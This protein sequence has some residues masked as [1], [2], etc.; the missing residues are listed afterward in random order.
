MMAFDACRRWLVTGC[1]GF[2]GSN[3]VE[4]LLGFGASVVGLDDLSTGHHANL[5]DIRRRV[6][7]EA[8]AR[9]RFI[10]GSIEDAE[11]C[12][13]ACEDV[14]FVLHQAAVASIGGS[15]K[16]PSM[17]NRV[18]VGGTI[19]VLLAAR[20][21][22]VQRVVYASS[23]SVYGDDPS[24]S[25]IESHLGRLLS[26]YA[27]SKLA[28]EQYAAV[29]EECYGLRCVGLRYFNVFGC[30]QDPNGPYAAVIPRWI[31]QLLAGLACEIFGD[32]RTSRDFCHVDNV[33]DA[34]FC[35]ALLPLPE[36]HGLVYNVACGEQMTLIDLFKIIR[37][38]LVQCGAIS[39]SPD[40]IFGEF[41]V[42]DVRHSL[43]DISR[44]QTDLGFSA[45]INVVDGLASVVQWYVD[46]AHS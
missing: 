18:N 40:V 5:D 22:G 27:V 4:K 20:D 6:G 17:T 35:A 34:N 31:A 15:I 21:A 9:F 33:V 30:R 28:G 44:I 14:D 45:A 16:N 43:A 10:E 39:T 13:A 2:I 11:D 29:F 7:E 12:R 3:L 37:D 25:K 8:F 41:R 1:A 36:A 26:P 19:N 32:G 42:G 23:S 46:Q 38:A 24:L